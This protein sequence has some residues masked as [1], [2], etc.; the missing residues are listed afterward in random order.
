MVTAN[1]M[2]PPSDGKP[3]FFSSLLVRLLC[4]ASALT[5]NG[6]R[7]DWLCGPNSPMACLLMNTPCDVII[8]GLGAIG[9]AAAYQLSRRG[10]KVLGLDRFHPPHQRGSSHGDTRITRLALGEGAEYLQFARRS[11]E[12]W[13]ELETSTGRTLLRQIGGLMF[14]S[15]S[16]RASAHGARDFLQTTIDVARAESLAHEVLDAA[17][18]HDRFPQF[19]WRGDELGCLEQSA[20]FVHP[21]ECIA[22]QLEMARR[23]GATLQ[24]GEQVLHWESHADGLKVFTDRG[25]YE[26]RRLVLTAGAWLPLFADSLASCARVFRQVMFWFEPDGPPELFTPARMPI[27]IR[28]PES[29]HAM[30]Y[31]FPAIDGAGGGIKIAGEQFEH[32][33]APDEMDTEVQ[34]HEIRAMHAVA[35][36]FLR[37]SE[38]CVRAVAC[39]YTVTPDFGFIIDRHPADERVL[40]ASACSG[41]GFKH[42]AAVGE[43]L[44]ELA[45]GAI[46]RYNL[47]PFRLSRFR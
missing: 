23:Q 24:A 30:F 43:A 29:V 27:F 38:R 8:A 28:I 7:R 26:T 1:L 47:K 40:F 21:E 31:G 39:K 32:S 18:L 17:A 2:S 11:H 25:T 35:S 9:S 22:A 10:A 33:V 5:G 19:H 44:A 36:P 42:S 15:A 41:H 12:I 4:L 6:P 46:S 20:G 37:I 16:C 14:G 34:E 45:T 3:I 13:R